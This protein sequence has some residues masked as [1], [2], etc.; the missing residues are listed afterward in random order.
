MEPILRRAP[1]RRAPQWRPDAPVRR[2][3][4]VRANANHVLLATA[5]GTAS[6]GARSMR[7]SV[8]SSVCGSPWSS[9]KLS[10]IENA[11]ALLKPTLR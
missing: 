10:V 7:I 2:G 5:S 6:V 9:P 3:L 4:L 8:S 11:R 1:R